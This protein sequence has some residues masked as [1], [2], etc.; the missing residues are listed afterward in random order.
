MI[1]RRSRRN[2]QIVRYTFVGLVALFILINLNVFTSFQANESEGP[3]A[4]L[5][6]EYNKWR[7][8]QQKIVLG[9]FSTAR[10]K[11]R[12]WRDTHRQ[13]HFQYPEVC[14]PSS[15]SEDCPILARFVLGR[16]PP[17]QLEAI[18]QENHTFGDLI[19]LDIEENMNN[20]KTYHW[21]K[22]VNDHFPFATFVAKSDTDTFVW[23]KALLGDLARFGAHPFAIYYGRKSCGH[24]IGCKMDQQFISGGFQIMSMDLVQWIADPLNRFVQERIQGYEDLI[25]GEWLHEGHRFVHLESPCPDQIEDMHNIFMDQSCGKVFKHWVK[26]PSQFHELY[27]TSSGA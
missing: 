21:W 12:Q 3:S 20:G 18:R 8:Q 24:R 6:V 1:N 2:N 9:F 23:M 14:A 19:E 27:A 16:V 11:D 25:T 22:Y 26:D 4:L 17:D 5:K 13:T 7:L 15:S 10:A